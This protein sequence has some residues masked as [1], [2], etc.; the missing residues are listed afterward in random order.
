M[1]FEGILIGIG[2]CGRWY[3]RIFFVV[4]LE[5]VKGSGLA[6]AVEI[7]TMMIREQSDSLG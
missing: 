7:V 2:D 6:Q 3:T 1:S 4:A 5:E